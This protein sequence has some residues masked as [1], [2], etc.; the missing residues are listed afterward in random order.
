MFVS[1]K[2]SSYARFQRALDTGN[3]TI[4]R[5]AAAELPRIELDD[6]LRICQAL[7]FDPDAYERDPSGG[8]ADSASSDPT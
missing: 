5:T 1:I 3:L 6:A 2:G 8:S 4:I 7:T